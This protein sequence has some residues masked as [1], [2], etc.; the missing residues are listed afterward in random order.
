MSRHVILISA[1]VL[2]ASPMIFAQ[3]EP[4]APHTDVAF[5]VNHWSQ[6]P[7]IVFGPDEEAFNQNMQVVM[8]PYDD[9]DEPSNISAL[10]NNVQWLKDHPNVRFYVDGYA[11]SRGDWLYNLR[12]SQRRANWVKQAMVSR[13]IAASRIKVAA[14]WGEMYPVCPETGDECWTKNRLVRFVYSPN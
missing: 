2:L 13:G 12:L 10:D 8:F 4:G 11:S 5:W 14:G 6:P 9:H 3:R 7:V 1:I